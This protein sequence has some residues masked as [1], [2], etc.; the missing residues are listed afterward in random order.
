MSGGARDGLAPGRVIRS[1]RDQAC[2][3][4]MAGGPAPASEDRQYVRPARVVLPLPS[5]GTPKQK[6]A[7]RCSDLATF[8]S[9][10]VERG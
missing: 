5:S 2:Q 3:P 4:D 6:S 1:L 7:G 10:S 9:R 8:R